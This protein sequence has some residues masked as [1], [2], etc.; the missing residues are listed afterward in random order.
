MCF[1]REI[2]YFPKLLK[3][4]WALSCSAAAVR[5]ADKFVRICA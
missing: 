3:D 1:Y 4:F 2:I 5:P